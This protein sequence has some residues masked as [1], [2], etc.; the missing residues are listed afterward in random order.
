MKYELQ[1]VKFTTQQV[2]HIYSLAIQEEERHVGEAI[3][4]LQTAGN[5]RL[6]GKLL[7]VL[8]VCA[9]CSFASFLFVHG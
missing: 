8:V 1:A 2:R 6:E 5:G 4:A 7:V 3:S 9:A